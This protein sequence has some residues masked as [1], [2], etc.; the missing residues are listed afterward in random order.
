MRDS[1]AW[2]QLVLVQRM[3]RDP[4]RPSELRPTRPVSTLARDVTF[5]NMEPMELGC[6]YG[7]RYWNAA[8]NK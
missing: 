6:E 7:V 8:A 1:R 5:V 3:E 2:E 4:E